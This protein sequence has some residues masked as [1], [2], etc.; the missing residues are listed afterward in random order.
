MNPQ[1][2]GKRLIQF[3][4]GQARIEADCAHDWGAAIITY[5]EVMRLLFTEANEWARE[6]E[7]EIRGAV[8]LL[9]AIREEIGT[10]QIDYTTCPFAD[11]Y[12]WAPFILVGD[13]H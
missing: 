9:T 7:E 1:Q 11:P 8:S 2:E 12:Y 10:R 6:K 13:W 5:Q 3:L 4:T